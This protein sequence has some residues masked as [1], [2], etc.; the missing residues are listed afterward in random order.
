MK[1]EMSHF[2]GVYFVLIDGLFYVMTESIPSLV[3]HT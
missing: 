3:H 2:G 1:N